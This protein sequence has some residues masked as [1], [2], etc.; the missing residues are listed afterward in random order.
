M[1][2]VLGFQ[3]CGKTYLSERSEEKY[4]LTCRDMDFKYFDHHTDWVK[5]YVDEVLEQDGYDIVFCNISRELINELLSR[6][7]S[8]TVVAPMQ[9]RCSGAEY[10]AIKEML[11]GR[12]VLRKTQTPQNVGWIEKL[13]ANFDSWTDYEF[14]KECEDND[15]VLLLPLTPQYNTMESV[16]MPDIWCLNLKET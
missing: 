4:G 14:F 13:K 3:G 15:N 10:Q 11:F 7:I 9:D 2:I 5:D 1:R 12:Y 6:D 8:F 16:L